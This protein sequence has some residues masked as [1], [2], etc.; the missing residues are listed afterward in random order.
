MRL[1]VTTL[2]GVISFVFLAIMISL[3]WRWVE[4]WFRVGLGCFYLGV[5]FNSCYFVFRFV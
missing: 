1:F 5:I 3:F 2:F 4:V